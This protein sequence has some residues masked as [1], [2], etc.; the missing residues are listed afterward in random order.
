MDFR[1][2]L[3]GRLDAQA[4]RHIPAGVLGKGSADEGVVG[5][6]SARHTFPH[7]VFIASGELHV[8]NPFQLLEAVAIAV[9]GILDGTDGRQ[10][11]TCQQRL[12]LL[13]HWALTRCLLQVL[14]QGLGIEPRDPV[15]LAKA[16]EMTF[17]QL[18]DLGRLSGAFT[19]GAF[20]R[21]VATER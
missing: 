5:Q 14:I 12:D 4:G 20:Y 7:I 11:A 2:L 13:L 18:I 6:G 15:K 1:Q 17:A 8:I 3:V 21:P 19:P 9:V 10:R 16:I